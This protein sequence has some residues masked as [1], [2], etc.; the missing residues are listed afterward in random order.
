MRRCLA[1]LILF[2]SGCVTV[3]QV[4]LEEPACRNEFSQAIASVLRSQGETAETADR[5]ADGAIR[6]ITL[7]NLGPRPF[8]I[9]SPSGTDYAFFVQ[10]KGPG[11][12]LRLY[13]RQ[14]GFWTYTNNLTYIETRQL[15]PCS[16][17]P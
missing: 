16:C 8:L 2:I 11:C 7:A 9:A 5:L 17:A 12:L 4:N 13:G 14:K 6:R 15:Q 10:V 1:A 3:G